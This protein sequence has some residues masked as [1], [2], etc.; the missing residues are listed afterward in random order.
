MPKKRAEYRL[1]PAAK[2]DLEGIWLYTLKEWGIEQ[3]HHYTDELTAAI[4]QLANNP[5]LGA[6]CETISGKG[7]AAAGWGDTRS[8]SASPITGLP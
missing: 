5:Q 2:R 8:I 6:S 4:G 1:A 7:I 3:A